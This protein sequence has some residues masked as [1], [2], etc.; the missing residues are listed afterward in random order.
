MVPG[1]GSSNLNKVSGIRSRDL[2]IGSEED[3]WNIENTNIAVSPG[4]FVVDGSTVAR[5]DTSVD[6]GMNKGKTKEQVTAQALSLGAAPLSA[7][8]ERL[9]DPGAFPP[10]MAA[11]IQAL[12]TGRVKGFEPLSAGGQPAVTPFS[13][14]YDI[15]LPAGIKREL[16]NKARLTL[17][18]DASLSTGTSPTTLNIWYFNSATQKFELE[19]DGRQ[20]DTENNTV[21]ALV[22]HFS[23]FVVLSSTPLYVSSTSAFAGA[24]IE[25]FNFPNPFNLETK[26]KVLNLNPG[27]GGPFGFGTAQVTTRGTIIRVGVPKAVSGPG[28]IRIFSLA[29]ELVREYD[30]GMLSGADGGTGSGT[31]FYFE[32]DGRNSAGREVASDVYFGEIKIGG[33]KKFWKMAVVK[34]PKYK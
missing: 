5:P 32:W 11:A 9:R 8:V 12:K 28:K 10:N 17:T 26:T 2:L 13:A 22:G 6:V 18:Y 27:G 30:C 24:E 4:S 34:D 14:F 33:Q 16:K 21:S 19:E 20:I 15:F 31:Y 1:A 7:D 3:A 25:V 29:G 23:T